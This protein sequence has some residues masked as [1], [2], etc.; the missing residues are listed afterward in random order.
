M[1]IISGKHRGTKLNTSEGGT[2]RPTTDRIKTTMFNMIA[3]D[4]PEETVLDMFAGS[5]ALGLECLSRGAKFATFLDVD[6]NANIVIKQNCEKVKE[7]G[8]S[9]IL[10]IDYKE[11]LDSNKKKFGLIFLD[12]PYSLGIHME[13]I[14]LIMEKDALEDDGIIVLEV[15]SEDDCGGIE[16]IGLEI[17]KMRKFPRTILYFLKKVN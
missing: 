2:T 5:G 11:F 3:F 10:N 12:P 7:I 15:S 16:E 1:R 8:H 17:Y 14:N 13:A 4:I 9:E 6:K